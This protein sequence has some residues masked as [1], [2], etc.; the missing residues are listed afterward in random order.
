MKDCSDCMKVH[1]QIEKVK[2][3]LTILAC[4]VGVYIW[5]T[6]KNIS[7]LSEAVKELQTPK[8]A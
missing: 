5:R 4:I 3:S 1:S 8:E 2:R 7:E 6:N